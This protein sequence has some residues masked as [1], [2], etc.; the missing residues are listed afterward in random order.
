M[1]SISSDANASRSGGNRAWVSETDRVKR[2]DTSSSCSRSLTVEEC[3]RAGR[4]RVPVENVVPIPILA[5]ELGKQ[6]PEAAGLLLRAEL[7]ADSEVSQ[8]LQRV[9][10]TLARLAGDA[11]EIMTE[12]ARRAESG[13]VE[14]KPCQRRAGEKD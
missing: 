10:A 2:A 9:A 11:V 13:T 14:L 8:H 1:E 7:R 4:R 3:D 5:D 12:P 6:R